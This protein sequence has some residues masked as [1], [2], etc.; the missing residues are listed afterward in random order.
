MALGVVA[1]VALIVSVWLVGMQAAD[2]VRDS[3]RVA[4]ERQTGQQ[5]AGC[6]R[7]VQRDFESWQTNQDLRAFALSAAAARRADKNVR[8][9]RRYEAIADRAAAR[10]VTIQT[11]LPER[12]DVAAATAFCIRLY[13]G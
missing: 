5:R 2:G 12:N 13:P 11:R 7:G 4:R 9:A 6:V 3:E 1:I 10:M 8:V